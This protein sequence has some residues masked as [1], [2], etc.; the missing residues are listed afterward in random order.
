MPGPVAPDRPSSISP[1]RDL[2]IGFQCVHTV[3]ICLDRFD[4]AVPDLRGCG[5]PAGLQRSLGTLHLYRA[6]FTSLTDATLGMSGWL[7]LTQRGLAPRKKRQASL[8]ARRGRNAG[9]P[10]PPAQIPACGFSAPGSSMRLASAILLRRRMLFPSGRL[11]CGSGPACP[12]QVS[13]EGYVSPSPPSPCGRLSRPRS[14][15]R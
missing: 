5:H 6:A 10:T 2:R 12:A 8:G 13:C 3:A 11:A 15:T 14:T 1:G 7:D 4:E 9:Y